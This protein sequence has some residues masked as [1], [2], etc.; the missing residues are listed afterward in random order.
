VELLTFFGMVWD[1][2]HIITDNVCM[3][4]AG[5]PNELVGKSGYFLIQDQNGVKTLIKFIEYD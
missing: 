2:S 4:V 1:N 5:I 3:L